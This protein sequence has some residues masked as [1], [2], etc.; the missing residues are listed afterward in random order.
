MT[1]ANQKGVIWTT[2]ICS[3][4]LLTALIWGLTSIS[5]PEVVVPTEGAIISGVLAGIVVPAVPIMDTITT[6][7]ICELTDGCEYWEPKDDHDGELKNDN[8]VLL[9][10]NKLRARQDFK[11][12]FEDLIGLDLTDEFTFVDTLNSFYEDETQIRAYSDNDADDDNWEVKTLLRVVYHDVDEDLGD[13]EVVYVVVTSV[14]DEGEYDEL[15]IEE[16]SRDFE[17]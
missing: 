17:F 15:S 7:R 16:V 14:L 6:D 11:N 8:A 1:Q 3:V 5:V 12:A 4:V 13:N 9:E 10:L 2:I